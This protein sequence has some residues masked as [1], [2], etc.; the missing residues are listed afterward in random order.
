MGRRVLLPGKAGGFVKV[1]GG[2][3]R[4]EGFRTEG[5]SLSGVEPCESGAVQAPLSAVFQLI[6]GEE[7]GV[8]APALHTH[9]KGNLLICKIGEG[10]EFVP[11]WVLPG[12]SQ[13]KRLLIADGIQGLVFDPFGP[14]LDLT[15]T[16]LKK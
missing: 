13:Q 16:T 7:L 10:E 4:E 14:V 8:F 2:Q 6:R 15:E 9:L 11:C 5:L 12:E 1:N 3:R